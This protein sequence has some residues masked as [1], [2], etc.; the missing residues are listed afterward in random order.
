[1]A[2]GT[3]LTGAD[4]AD[5]ADGAFPFTGKY[6]SGVNSDGEVIHQEWREKKGTLTGHW[7][8]VFGPAKHALSGNDLNVQDTIDRANINKRRC[9]AQETRRDENGK[10]P[11]LPPMLAAEKN[12]EWKEEARDST[13]CTEWKPMDEIL[14]IAKMSK[15][16]GKGKTAAIY[17]HYAASYV[18]SYSS[19]HAEWEIYIRRSQNQQGD[20]NYVNG[21]ALLNCGLSGDSKFNVKNVSA[22]TFGKKQMKQMADDLVVAKV[23]G[24][25]QRVRLLLQATKDAKIENLKAMIAAMKASCTCDG[26]DPETDGESSE[27]KNSND[28]E[29]DEVSLRKG[30]NR[31]EK[32]MVKD[33]DKVVLVRP[34]TVSVDSIHPVTIGFWDQTCMGV[35]PGILKAFNGDYDGDEMHLCPVYSPGAVNECSNWNCTPEQSVRET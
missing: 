19:Q 3:E 29:G 34:P 27:N 22:E 8:K 24:E 23:E 30:W 16:E 33:G 6:L 18:Y 15:G 31:Y 20:V 10:K 13:P 28:D 14:A 35:S 12:S 25:N 26:K 5:N 7:V 17:R 11:H 4:D 9:T 32:R 2:S 21:A 1:M